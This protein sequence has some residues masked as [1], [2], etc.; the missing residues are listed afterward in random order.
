MLV[1]MLLTRTHENIEQTKRLFRKSGLYDPAKTDRFHGLDP[2]TN[3]PVTYLEMT[4]QKA[5]HLRKK[6]G[7]KQDTPLSG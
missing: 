4:V 1:L 3:Q 2:N 7:E 6:P 5:L